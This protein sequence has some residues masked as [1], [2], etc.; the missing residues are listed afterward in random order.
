[1][2]VI[3][4]RVVAR[5]KPG[6]R[7]IKAGQDLFRQ[8]EP[9]DEIY[10]L[11]DGW[12]VLYELFEDARRQ[13]LHFAMPEAVLGSHPAQGRIAAYG[14]EAV[15]DTVVCVIPHENL[16]P[17]SNEH[18]EIGL[19]LAEWPSRDL[20]LAYD[21]LSS[22]GRRT[23]RQR[24]AHLLLEL[25]VRYR[26]QWPGH[27]PER[28]YLPLTQEHI[29]DAT[30]LSGVHVNRVLGGLRKEG[31]VSFHYRRL[32]ILD[33]DKLVEVAGTDPQTMFS[34]TR[35]GTTDRVEAS[36]FSTRSAISETD[37]Y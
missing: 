15:T 12:V 3:D 8:G 21:H 7:E 25:F 30:G 18:P 35:S 17:L 1:M 32:Q 33:P 31:I 2:C 6:D 36:V 4:Q 9:C 29:G 10:Y 11:V 34:W 27:H 20:S 19:R 28:M 5:S 26:M 24:V 16:G 13:I 22:L 37:C 23:A 14:A